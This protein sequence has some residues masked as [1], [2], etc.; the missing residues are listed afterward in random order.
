[1]P[2]LLAADLSHFWPTQ[3]THI[4]MLTTHH[5]HTHTH[6]HVHL[7]FHMHT[8]STH[9]VH[10]QAWVQFVYTS[11]VTCMCTSSAWSSRWLMQSTAHSFSEWIGL[12]LRVPIANSI[13]N[14]VS[15]PVHNLHSMLIVYRCRHIS[16]V[17]NHSWRVS[18]P[19]WTM[20]FAINL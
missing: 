17:T 1:M 11:M 10:V 2:H 14:H 18:S 4:H 16:A 6:S 8:H 20:P 15:T 3:H 13:S 9:L 12:L 5:A 7:H 19:N